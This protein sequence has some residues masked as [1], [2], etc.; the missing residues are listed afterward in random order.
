MAVPQG[1][2]AYTR[3]YNEAV[4]QY[5]HVLRSGHRIDNIIG[6]SLGGL[7]SN[8][9]NNRL[10]YR[11]NVRIYDSPLITGVSRIRSNV[12]HTA[13]VADPVSSLD[14]TAHRVPFS[15]GHYHHSDAVDP[16]AIAP[17]A[18]R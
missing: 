18:A 9:M 16:R 2:V 14:F 15:L 7:I 3:R 8:E 12:R 4:S 5:N 11:G 10:Q 17:A 1:R 13:M 6:Q